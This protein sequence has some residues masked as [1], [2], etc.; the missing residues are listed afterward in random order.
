MEVV[1]QELIAIDV[2][3]DVMPQASAVRKYDDA[4]DLMDIDDN[5]IEPKIVESTPGSHATTL[6]Q[7]EKTVI[8][9]E[10]KEPEKVVECEAPRM[11]PLSKLHTLIQ[12]VNYHLQCKWFSS[13]IFYFLLNVRFISARSN[14]M[15]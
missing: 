12:E 7:S 4:L 5:E 2:P 10:S 14:M 13:F 1:P 15:R 6:E 3:D 11:M 8:K 9:I